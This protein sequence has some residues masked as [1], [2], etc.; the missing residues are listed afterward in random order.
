[1]KMFVSSIVLLASSAG[2]AFADQ[3]PSPDE[4]ARIAATAKAWGCSGGS[5]E[6]ETE[7]SGVF[8]LDDAKCADGANYDFKLDAG[9]KVI[10]ITAD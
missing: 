6:K 7:A 2:I 4:A 9:Y 8:E 1:M 5:P 10:S 3:P